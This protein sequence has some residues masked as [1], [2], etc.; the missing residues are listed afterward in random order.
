MCYSIFLVM[1]IFPIRSKTTC[2]GK[3]KHSRGA[4][5]PKVGQRGDINFN[6]KLFPG[7]IIKIFGDGTIECAYDG[8]PGQTQKFC[9][10]DAPVFFKKRRN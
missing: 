10:G 4:A 8:Y 3:R 6:G 7:R 2:L 9:A 5:A 1:L